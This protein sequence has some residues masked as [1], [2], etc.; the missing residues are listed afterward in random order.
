MMKKNNSKQILEIQGLKKYFTN[1]NIINKAVNDVSFNLHEG[2]IV[3]LIG[4]SG[5]G[6]TTVGRSLL[7]LYE[8]F[9][10]FVMLDGK[11]ISG[12]RISRS[13]TKFLRKNI[14]M[15]FQDPHASLNGQKNIYSTLKEPLIVN[16][17]IKSQIKDIF[18]DWVEIKENYFYTFQEKYKQLQLQNLR[19]I[20]TLA[21]DFF[22]SWSQKA[23]NWKIDEN[24]SFEDNFNS[25]FSYLEEKQNMESLI[26]N[27]LYQ[28][29]DELM[30]FYFEKQ[31]DFRN[32]NLD[33]DESELK[34]AKEHYLKTIELSKKTLKQYNLEQK[35][36]QWQNQ[37][38][39]INKEYRDEKV[40]NINTFN[41]F[42]VEFKK[43]AKI[44]RNSKIISTNLN[45]YTHNLKNEL[46]SKKMNKV[47]KLM[48]QQL[49]YLHYSQAKQVINQLQEYTKKFFV[50]YLSDI[51][52]SS[53]IKH[54]IN[55]VIQQHFD[56]NFDEY[57]KLNTN[58]INEFRAK[59][60]ELQTKINQDVV[61]GSSQ[62]Y[63]S[64]QDI[65]AAKL[66]YEKAKKFNQKMI[67]EYV[68]EH[69]KRIAVLDL[70][71]EQANEEYKSLKQLQDSTNKD[72]DN[73][74]K[75]FIKYLKLKLS[76]LKQDYH[77][78]KASKS[79]QAKLLKM[80]LLE[81]SKVLNL[82]VSRVKDKLSTLKSFEIEAKYLTKDINAIKV[83][84][85][86][87]TARAVDHNSVKLIKLLSG[88]II[89]KTLIKNLLI[90]TTIY[91][92]LEDV[93]LLK[94]YAYR[95][96]HEFSGGQRQ[97]IVI[98]RALITQPKVIVADEPIASLDISIQ[99]QV[100][101]LLKDLC[102]KK[103]I[104]MIFIAHDLSMIEYI[105]DRVQI[106]HYGKIVESGSTQKVYE[107]PIHPYTINLF[108]AIP[109][110]SNANE[111]F[112]N[113]S[114]ELDYFKGQMYPNV[115]ELFEVEKEHFVYGTYQQAQQWAKPFNLNVNKFES[116]PVEQ[117]NSSNSLFKWAYLNND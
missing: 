111:K 73:A 27:N 112:E 81:H 58:N 110:I 75:E 68:I 114:F 47:T 36:K 20:N 71:I 22:H 87:N 9:N 60:T 90:K 85:G 74:H 49:K 105:A 117:A 45:V 43:D 64:K 44:Y 82:Y 104:G 12:K 34:A 91:K 52:Y 83:L 31:S 76:Q 50:Q 48:K 113:I 59:I 26:V 96:P 24:L 78:I 98:A 28:N 99:A 23:K 95:Y 37:V 1:G 10:G 46:L 2:E 32:L 65:E 5:S 51:E 116:K 33:I 17:I 35:I 107:K 61:G 56:F 7:R 21:H 89:A 79:E 40:T 67:E 16:G 14:Q 39:D 63:A 38:Q 19:S 94:Q 103:N 86:I 3:G 41:N 62:K 15:I 80:Q 92:S 53:K 77:Q 109:K 13:Q 69:Q 100:V 70:E 66:A 18:K 88:N 8:D 29:T 42:I 54:K 25:Y 106:M 101:N 108:K 102:E 93:G 4:E 97:R 30:N 72:I 57:I 55:Q 6:K 84:L 115:P 11:V